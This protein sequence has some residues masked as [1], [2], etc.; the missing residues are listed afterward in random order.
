MP[1]KQRV[2]KGLCALSFAAFF[3]TLSAQAQVAS[4][5]RGLDQIVQMYEGSNAK[6]PDVLKSHI[7]SPSGE[8]L[9][10]VRL[11]PGVTSAQALPQL[12]AAGFKL[13][14][15]S[16]LD[17]RL[18]EGYLPLN[19]VQSA[20]W[21]TGVQNILAVQ[22]P[23]SF[24]GK[25]QSQAVAIEKADLAQA[26]G[27]DGKGTRVG[28][29]SDSFANITAPISAADDVASGDL[30]AD[31]VVLQDYPGTPTD[32]GEDEGRAMAQL[33]HDVAPGAKLGFAT[34]VIGEVSFS[35]NILALRRKFNADVIVDDVG[36]FDEPMY[37]DGLLAQT[38][39][40]VVSEGAAYFSAAGNNGVEAFEGVYRSISFAD[41]QKLVAAGKSNLDLAALVAAGHIPKSLH[42]FG[43]EDRKT[44]ISQTFTTAAP[45]GVS[46]QWDEPFFLGKVKTNFDIYVFDSAGHYL[47]PLDPNFPGFYTTDD[48]TMTDEAVEVLILPPFPG[49]IHGGAN[50]STYQIV[51]ANMNGGPARHVKYVNVNGLGISERQDAPSIFGHA[52]ARRGQ[53]VGAMY[54]AITKFPEDFSSPGPVTIYFDNAGN[55]KREPQV[56]FVPQITGIDGVDTTFFG[57][58]SDGNGLPNF[59]GTSA[60]AP[61]V[62]AVAALALEAAGGPGSLDPEDLYERLQETAQPV[63]LSSNRTL[64]GAIA[65]PVVASAHEDW[66]RLARYFSL[67]VLPTSKTVSS[68]AFDVSKIGLTFSAN[69]NRFNIGT[70]SGLTAADITHATSASGSVFT[71]TFAPNKFKAGA[72]LT[73]GMSVFSP[74]LGSTQEDADRFEGMLVTVTFADGSTS[75]GSFFVAPKTPYNF[76]TGA[77]L[78]NADRATRRSRR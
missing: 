17:P 40:Q 76:F 27:I 47:D 19:L 33:I 24:A 63:W 14:A 11:Q 58:D 23:T 32:H 65:G 56:R 35:N 38:V 45:N 70:I 78:V 31:V 44:S 51:I 43:G 74:L 28:I 64:S 16:E 8:V 60:S 29:L 13:Q 18:L 2:L 5:G 4:L 68:V 77:G 12:T 62:A 22:R 1:T 71:L 34:A 69:P 46:F 26:R 10:H 61:D 67:G 52:A 25:V 3:G 75:K 39:D 30:P 66:T 54:Y 53:A 7:M 42:L 20:R 59:F 9:V 50:V 6:L 57:F 72:S 73:F 37:S 36:Y 15:V 49:E 55:K 41:A 48:N 21:V